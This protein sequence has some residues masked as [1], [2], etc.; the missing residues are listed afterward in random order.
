M[1]QLSAI[2]SCGARMNIDPGRLD[3]AHLPGEGA[4]APLASRPAPFAWLRGL[5]R[6]TAPSLRLH[7]AHLPFGNMP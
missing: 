5:R 6:G 3:R 7:A 1:R 2:E 4:Q